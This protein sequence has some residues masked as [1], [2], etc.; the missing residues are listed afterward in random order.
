MAQYIYQMHGMFEMHFLA[1][2]GSAI[3]ITYRNWKLQIPLATV[4]IVH[5]A[6]FGYLQF[7]GFDKIYFTQ[8]EY[9]TLQTFIIHG[10]LATT[11]FFLCGLWSYNFKV[12]D[13]RQIAQRLE[14]ERIFNTIGEVLF[15]IDPADNRVIQ[16]SV[17]C[18][19]V[20]GYSP[21]EFMEDSSL[22]MK[23]IHPRD[24]HVVEK[25]EE[26]LKE[27]KTVTN[28]YRIIH[29]DKTVHWIEAKI[30][31]TLNQNGDLVSIDGVCNDIT[32][33]INLEKQ[34][35]QEIKQKQ[36]YITAAAITA[37]EKERSFIGEEL[38]DNINP[39]L[40]TA[41]LYI[42]CAIANDEGRVNLIESSK[43]FISTAIN[44][45]RTLSNSLIP[46]PFKQIAVKDAIT[47]ITQ[48]I[49]RA[50][51]L[52]FITNWEGL[53]ESLLSDKMKLTIYRIVQEQLNN[54][55]KHAKAATVSIEIKQ[56][57]NFLQLNIKDDGVGFDVSEK[58]AGVGLQ[59][60]I[61]RTEL[62][63]GQVSINSSPGNGCELNINFVI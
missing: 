59:N 53:N 18:K 31:P 22:W 14:L 60:I 26:R 51:D 34:L 21:S 28:Q 27:G 45:I 40:A 25:N 5:H 3:L 2:I 6:A 35:A 36:Q 37:Q 8:L 41:R 10:L 7:I 38:H 20:Y 44:E 29:R 11:I 58:R 12:S 57:H 61:S 15:S 1:F 23:V 9:M 17:A 63:N 24:K 55:L 49:N 42:D 19:R 32:E 4:V 33:R 13:E 16:M 47:D 39:I 50:Y 52:Q 48:N 30:I 43:V 62:F 54:I 46:K 56:Q